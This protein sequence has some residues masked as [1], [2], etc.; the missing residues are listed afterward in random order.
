MRC[1]PIPTQALVWLGLCVIG[2]LSVHPLGAE[3]RAQAV[4]ATAAPTQLASICSVTTVGGGPPDITIPDDGNVYTI[5]G[6]ATC[7]LI[8]IEGTLECADSVTA[9]IKTDG[10]LVSGP[11]AKL[12]CGTPTARFD[13]DVVFTIQN[14]RSFPAHPGHGERAVL[15]MGGGTLSLHGDNAKSGFTRIDKD[16]DA[17]DT[18]VHVIDASGW[19]KGDPIIVTTTSTYPTQTERM[20]LADA[21]PSNVCTTNRAFDYFH[22]GDGQQTYAGAGEGGRDLTVDLRAFAANLSRNITIEGADDTHWGGTYPK[23]GH[24]MIMPGATAQIDAVELVRMGQQTILARYPVH[25]HHGGPVPGQYVRNSAIHDS[26]SRCVT[27]HNTHHADVSNNVCYDVIGHAIFLENGNEVKNTIRGNLLADVIEPE[28][29]SELLK[30]D[31]DTELSRWRGPAGVWVSNPDNTIEDNVVVNA[32]SGYWHAYVHKLL[33]YDDPTDPRGSLNGVDGRYCNHV[34][35]SEQNPL[36]WNVEPVR[37]ATLVYRDNVAVA[38]RVGHTWDGAPDGV[39]VSLGNEFDRD[40]IVTGYRPPSEQLFDGMHAYRMGKTA[41]YYRGLSDTALIR[42][43]VVV[44]APIGWFGTQDQDFFDSVFVGVGAAYRGASQIDEDW[45]YHADTSFPAKDRGNLNDLF[46]GWGLYDGGNYFR[47]VTFDYPT[48]PMK[49]ANKEVT[50]VPISIFGRA[51][52][53]NHILAR[54]HFVVDPYR[55]INFDDQ[56][57]PGNW[58]DTQGSESLYD[59]DGSLFGSPGYLRPDILFNELTGDCVQEANHAHADPSTPDS[60][61]LRCDSPTHSVKIQ[62]GYLSGV[63]DPNKQAF[64]VENIDSAGTVANPAPDVLF[65]KFQ[66]YLDVPY[67]VA[68]L[69]FKSGPANGDDHDGNLIWIETVGYGD[70]TPVIIIDGATA[71]DLA[72]SC[73]SPSDYFLEGWSSPLMI[74]VATNAFDLRTFSD[75]MFDGAYYQDPVSGD[76]LLK[77][78]GYQQTS[79]NPIPYQHQGEGKFDLVCPEI[80]ASGGGRGRG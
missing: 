13:G 66:T 68:G 45:Y 14:D 21:C 43:A 73:T 67:R 32:G 77:L 62:M 24:L 48:S 29:G 80:G 50:P 28:A 39:Q 46:Q 69:D 61:L 8:T 40:L 33:C 17:T 4:T 25:W 26:A 3:A 19:E 9:Q 37:T 65:D 6:N 42:N 15:V 53:G 52:F 79:G 54:I 55:V 56:A 78:R 5:D 2:G 30:S 76:L 16:L 44:E 51:H 11:N 63:G 34:D 41:I 18:Q 1:V 72:S 20:T 35:R 60:T 57:F 38:T 27:L 70:W 59:I 23:G 58:K 36:Y 47:N 10:I 12:E 71:F 64:T 22:Y 74:Y 31:V 7:G 49:I 75:P